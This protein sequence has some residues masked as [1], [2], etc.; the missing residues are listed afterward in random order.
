MPE[1][2]MSER[3]RAKEVFAMLNEKKPEPTPEEKRIFNAR[4]N[5]L[6][7]FVIL[8]LFLGF[9]FIFSRPWIDQEILQD[10][11]YFLG[12]QKA[13][14]VI[15]AFSDYS[16][17][18]C[19]DFDKNVLSRLRADH[20][21]R[22]KVK[23]VFRDF[24]QD[25]RSIG[26]FNASLSAE[27]AGEQGKYWEMHDSLFSD[28]NSFSLPNLKAQAMGL[29]LD[30]VKFD[31]C[32]SKKKYENEIKADQEYGRNIGVTSPPTFFINA[33]KIVGNQPYEV[34]VAE[35]DEALK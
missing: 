13:P 28:H 27:C 8:L 5:L 14:V 6:A 11:P 7:M 33:K 21:R 24:L 30:S 15:V 3:E 2:K 31:L 12:D 34:F 22:G 9:V 18:P 25:T 35:I 17:G 29:G 19:A 32:M 16:C 23:F 1:K 4:V 10:K 26:A 20:I